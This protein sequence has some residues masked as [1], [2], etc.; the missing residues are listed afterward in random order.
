M[1]NVQ[2][3]N[4]GKITV[5]IYVIILRFLSGEEGGSI[6]CGRLE[7]DVFLVCFFVLVDGEKKER[8]LTGWGG[9]MST[10]NSCCIDCVNKG[11]REGESRTD[12]QRYSYPLFP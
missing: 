1:F 4:Y 9:M 8:R 12:Q 6:K 7:E 11:E 5:V 10:G 2:A 3:I